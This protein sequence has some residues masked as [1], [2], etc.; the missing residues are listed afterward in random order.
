MKK[1]Y[2]AALT[3]A[4]TACVSNDDLNPVENYGYIDVNVSNDPIVETRAEVN[5]LTNW[6]V[7]I[8]ETEYKGTG[9]AFAAGEYNVSVTTHTD[10]DAA[11]SANSPWGEAFY[12][13]EGSNDKV[14]VI[15]GQRVTANATCGSAKNARMNVV[16]TDNFKNV[17]SEYYLIISSPRSITYDGDGDQPSYF[18]GSANV[19]FTIKY[20]YGTETEYR[21]TDSQTIQIGANGTEKILTVTSNTD[22]NIEV[23]ISTT[24]F[25]QAPGTTITFNAADGTVESTTQTPTTN[26]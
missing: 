8:G 18:N 22:G 13:N 17:F 9:Q 14:T 10:V 6:I 25:S 2:L 20:K 23:N 16:F 3:L 11:N 12:N 26:Q 19:T 1:I 21:V 24:D 15:A 5:D 4:M 7:T